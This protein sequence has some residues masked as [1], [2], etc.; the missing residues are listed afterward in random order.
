MGH[1]TRVSCPLR[2]VG[3]RLGGRISALPESVRFVV[4]LN[5]YVA[6]SEWPVASGIAIGSD[7]RGLLERAREVSR[8]DL[9][10]FVLHQ[11]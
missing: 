10:K 2:P 5:R 7:A 11:P 3:P 6:R 4:R 8:G 1:G 9:S